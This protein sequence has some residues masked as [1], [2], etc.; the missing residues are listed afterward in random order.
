[1]SDVVKRHGWLALFCLSCLFC[2]A[3]IVLDARMIV[4]FYFTPYHQPL[5]EFLFPGVLGIAAFFMVTAHHRI[6]SGKAATVTCLLLLIL[7]TLA[8][9]YAT[10]RGF[11]VYLF[12]Q[13]FPLAVLLCCLI[14]TLLQRQT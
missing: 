1:M 6:R 9:S 11:G 5:Y 7:L 8:V 10:H 14:K 12:H 4:Y 2:L 13:T 3:L